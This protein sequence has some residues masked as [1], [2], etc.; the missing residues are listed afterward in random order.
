MLALVAWY[1]AGGQP[2]GKTEPRPGGQ[3]DVT[4]VRVQSP[5]FKISKATRISGPAEGVRSSALG[6]LRVQAQHGHSV[7]EAAAV[8]A[9]GALAGS[10]S[11][12]PLASPP[13]LSLQ[14]SPRHTAHMR[15][16][17]QR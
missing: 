8:G 1:S 17:G 6:A 5:V 15:T 13:S 2:I 3:V 7:S 11:E 9:G 12:R 10:S 16:S 4:S 14:F